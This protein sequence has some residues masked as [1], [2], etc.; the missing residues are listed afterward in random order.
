MKNSVK[1][2]YTLVVAALALLAGLAGCKKMNTSD[3]S[4]PER[5]F[6]PGAVKVSAGQTAA[7]VTWTNSILT[8]GGKY[9]YTA[10]FSR[11]T[12][13]ATVDFTMKS[14]TTGVTATNDSLKVRTKYWVRVKTNAY[15]NQ[16]ESKW[17]ESSAFQISG[18]Q[19]F[20]AVRELEIK[21]TSVTLRFTNT[22]GLSKITLT[23]AQG[24][25][26]DVALSAADLTAGLKVITGLNA[27]T[28]YNAELYAGTKSK[29]YT[30][31]TTLPLTV[32]TT[33]LNAGADLN[34]AVS[35]AANGDVI[36]LNPGTYTAS[37]TNTIFLLKNV[38]IK[39][40]SGNPSDTKVLFKEF[41]LKGNGAGLKL[42]GIECDGAG[43]AAYFINLTGAVADADAATFSNVTVENCYVHN[44]T[45]CF[46]RANRAALAAHKI[47]YIKV[48]NTVAYDNAVSS[49]DFFTL[50]KLTFNSLSVTKSTFYNLSR[51][52]VN[53][54][55]TQ[56]AGTPA[57][58]ISFDRCTIN[59]LGT[60]ASKYVLVDV[61]ANP[62]TI[63]FTNCIMGNVPRS[64]GVAAAAIRGSASTITF[65]NNNEFKF[66]TTPGGTTAITLPTNAA[67][68][69]TVDPGWTATTTDFTLAQDSPLRIAS[70]TA[71]PIGDPRWAY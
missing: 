1:T 24:A 5:L 41:T 39:S 34:A 53:S 63:A 9:T 11:D 13:F 64:G 2:K 58:S 36:G 49:Y 17:A 4:G 51:S 28:A 40:T 10:Q 37:A 3:I 46:L 21:E 12:T 50:D 54:T 23:P 60:D 25:A 38:T 62:A 56:P 22:P 48:T 18:E 43:T 7:Q 65:S 32:Y 26:T 68:N 44:I 45:T 6:K 30:T 70:P 59:N 52:L 69:Q 20:L 61:N 57:P 35:A 19:Y 16:P 31:F 66:V 14:D 27:N 42:S 71:G 15:Q 8:S 55:T 47:D 29:G 33:I 67:F